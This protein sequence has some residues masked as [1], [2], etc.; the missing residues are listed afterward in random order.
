MKKDIILEE[1][2]RINELMGVKKNNYE[3][4]FEYNQKPSNLLTEGFVFPPAVRTLFKE[5]LQSLSISPWAGTKEIPFDF[6]SIKTRFNIE[7]NNDIAYTLKS[8]LDDLLST[9]PRYAEFKSKFKNNPAAR[10]V[11]I[12]IF[13]SNPSVSDMFYAHSVM[14]F[15]NARNMPETEDFFFDLLQS[16]YRNSSNSGNLDEW[17]DQW[18]I[19]E[20]ISPSYNVNVNRN[21]LDDDFFYRMMKPM[22][23]DKMRGRSQGTMR[24]SIRF[25]DLSET[26]YRL[27]A[28]RDPIV[29]TIPGRVKAGLVGVSRSVSTAISKAVRTLVLDVF[30]AGTTMARHRMWVD[31]LR[32]LNTSEE[33][34]KKLLPQYELRIRKIIQKGGKNMNEDLSSL[35]DE[36]WIAISNYG[37]P[38]R[39]GQGYDDYAMIKNHFDFY[40]GELFNMSDEQ[41]LALG[42]AFRNVDGSVN[43][44]SLNKVK[45]RM[46]DPEWIDYFTE[47]SRDWRKNYDYLIGI[48]VR[49]SFRKYPFLNFFSR[50]WG[51]N[52]IG[53][54]GRLNSNAK[55]GWRKIFMETQPDKNKFLGFF[56]EDLPKQRFKQWGEGGN[57]NIIRQ[58]AFDI[59]FPDPAT[60]IRSAILQRGLTATE[61]RLTR[62]VMGR[63]GQFTSYLI[64]LLVVDLVGLPLIK[65]IVSGFWDS[66]EKSDAQLV[67]DQLTKMCGPK[68]KF[69]VRENAKQ[70]YPNDTEKAEGEINDYEEFCKNIDKEFKAALKTKWS[71]YFLGNINLLETET[72]QRVRRYLCE[73]NK[74]IIYDIDPSYCKENSYY[75]SDK[76]IGAHLPGM[77]KLLIEPF[78]AYILDCWVFTLNYEYKAAINVES[79]ELRHA[80]STAEKLKSVFECMGMK[81][82]KPTGQVE[83]A[84]NESF[85][86]SFKQYGITY[87]CENT[88]EQNI[89]NNLNQ[90]GLTID[91]FKEVEADKQKQKTLCIGWKNSI[92]EEKIITNDGQSIPIFYPVKESCDYLFKYL[93]LSEL[94]GE[95]F[96]NLHTF[97]KFD[98]I[99][100]FCTSKCN[101]ESISP[102]CCP[103]GEYG[104]NGNRDW[105][106]NTDQNKLRAKSD[107]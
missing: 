78:D 93:K 8:M 17:F 61:K 31:S 3:E 28:Y 39:K 80:A 95:T 10:E 85:M 48:D 4:I 22:I 68:Q 53:G 102:L 29:N 34:M 50:L 36:L 73:Q 59:I 92:I 5:A 7:I 76:F 70:K 90:F 52:E 54:Y 71:D 55:E 77:S 83:T 105:V 66:V 89:L 60:I 47:M 86:E 43:K 40:I 82:L 98:E 87:R 56:D 74:E 35:L 67:L 45:E 11:F 30:K 51:W 27:K 32:D 20:I 99:G 12:K 42:Y 1:L 26:N 96:Q 97:V 69:Q 37:A 6:P 104:L 106:C 25:E 94:S 46:S 23:L 14:D 100:K 75:L 101:D 33:Q 64:G 13:N 44:T 81:Y 24:K 38:T 58:M 84:I 21:T 65:M 107:C 57:W 41:L 2:I 15:L 49:R 63:R 79:E 88:I 16:N 19:D 62:S 18:W 72:S 91:D 103:K 9:P